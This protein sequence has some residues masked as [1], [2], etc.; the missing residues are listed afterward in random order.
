[1][2]TE[3][4]GHGMQDEVGIGETRSFS[5]AIPGMTSTFPLCNGLNKI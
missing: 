4:S 1:M 3:P 2:I 5:E